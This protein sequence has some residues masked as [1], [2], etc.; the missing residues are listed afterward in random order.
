MKQNYVVKPGKLKV[1][2][3]EVMAIET[4]L[5]HWALRIL[6]DPIT[7]E[8]CDR[9]HFPKFGDIP[10]ARVFL[11]NSP[12]FLKWQEGQD[13]YE[14]STKGEKKNDVKEFLEEIELDRPTYEYF[15]MS[16]PILDV[17]GGIGT[18]R[19]FLSADSEF[20]SVD[21][22]ISAPKSVP[23]AKV[24]AYTALAS[25]LNFIGGCAEFLPFRAETFDWVHMRSMLD[26]VQ[27]PDLSVIEAW[28][29][30][31]VGGQILIGL[32]VEGGRPGSPA[33]APA[34]KKKSVRQRL[35]SLLQRQGEPDH[36]HHV[37]YPTFST[38]HQLMERN[39]FRVKDS[40][41]QP[42]WDDRVV[43][44]LAEKVGARNN[45]ILAGA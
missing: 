24:E 30:L 44:L 11:S 36:D 14:A 12:D 16:G 23:P 10:D 15:K 38:L 13:H 19:Q 31:R 22:F 20:I 1:R 40:Y 9:E 6:A 2:Y 4:H 7:K 29:V 28:R 25:P 33:R 34:R 41:W 42:G 27:S 37:W 26:H 3:M 5:D 32:S 39:G 43:Y 35:A 45:S 18:V 17:G 21:P 8:P